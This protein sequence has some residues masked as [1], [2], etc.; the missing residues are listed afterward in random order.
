MT[1]IDKNSKILD[2]SRYL[3]KKIVFHKI[4]DKRVYLTSKMLKFVQEE[5]YF[6]KMEF[7]VEDIEIV[8]YYDE[9]E[10]RSYDILV[11]KLI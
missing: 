8:L 6:C 11:A 2:F 5:G 7:L 1:K 9:L 3:L 4:C 10:L